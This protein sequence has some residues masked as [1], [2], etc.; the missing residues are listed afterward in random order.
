M[1]DRKQIGVQMM[2]EGVRRIHEGVR[3]MGKSKVVVKRGRKQEPVE[4]KLKLSFAL[5]Q[6]EE[7]GGTCM[8]GELTVPIRKGAGA[9]LGKYKK[10]EVAALL[11]QLAEM[12]ETGNYASLDPSFAAAMQAGLAGA[13]AGHAHVRKAKP[14]AN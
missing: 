9:R 3:A 11:K 2:R 14:D 10:E 4:Y 1:D 7:L 6:S 8:S 12:I 13:K 5:Q